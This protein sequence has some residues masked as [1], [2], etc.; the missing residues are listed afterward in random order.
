MLMTV[1]I[2]KKRTPRQM[3]MGVEEVNKLFVEQN[4]GTEK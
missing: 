4:P 1:E 3:A 2:N